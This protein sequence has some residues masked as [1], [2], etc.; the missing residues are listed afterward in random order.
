[1]TETLQRNA[2]FFSS[3]GRPIYITGNSSMADLG[4]FGANE[5][6]NVIFMETR[7]EKEKLHTCAS[8]RVQDDLNK[9]SLVC[10]I[11]LAFCENRI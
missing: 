3:L 6:S 2:G 8:F 5:I 11:K 9:L 4:F 1:M 10:V 7:S